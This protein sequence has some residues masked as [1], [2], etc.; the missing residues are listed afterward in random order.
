MGNIKDFPELLNPADEDWI[1]IQENKSIPAYKKTQLI[2]I[3]S[4]GNSG[5]YSNVWGYRDGS[6]N[7]SINNGNYL[8]N[9]PQDVTIDG[10]VDRRSFD[11]TYEVFDGRPRYE[12]NFNCF[13]FSKGV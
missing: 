10:K 7:F 9:T 2:N 11:G 12:L 4:G 13:V 1:L 5:S 8:V 3:K 6:V